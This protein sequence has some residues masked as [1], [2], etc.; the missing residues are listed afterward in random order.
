MF[1]YV[2][3]PAAGELRLVVLFRFPETGHMSQPEVRGLHVYRH[4]TDV[5]LNVRVIDL[6]LRG[7]I[8]KR[9]FVSGFSRSQESGCI[10]GNEA[11]L[12]PLLHILAWITNDVLFRN[13]SS[14]KLNQMAHCCA[15]S[16]RIPP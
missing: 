3:R 8:F 5:M 10:V 9:V 4:L 12:P 14:R 15:H 13:E 16:N 1:N 6:L 2:S 11:G 7:D